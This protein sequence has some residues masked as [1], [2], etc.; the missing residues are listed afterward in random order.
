MPANFTRRHDL[1]LDAGFQNPN[2]TIEILLR[3]AT[4][5]GWT[6][7][8]ISLGTLCKA[9]HEADLL[10]RKFLLLVCQLLF[11]EQV[12]VCGFFGEIIIKH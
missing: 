6:A 12:V 11:F 2:S 8:G 4:E 1:F 5:K 9:L 3:Q 7:D 10:F